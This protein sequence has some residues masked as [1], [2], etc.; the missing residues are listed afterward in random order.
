MDIEA[1]MAPRKELLFDNDSSDDNPLILILLFSRIF[2][3]V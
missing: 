2:G 3:E 1:G